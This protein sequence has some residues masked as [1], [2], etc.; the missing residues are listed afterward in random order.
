MKY[1]AELN[2]G[3][4]KYDPEDE[5]VSG[6]MDKLDVVNAAAERS[7]GFV[8]RL[9]DTDEGG[10]TISAYDDPRFLINLSVWENAESFEKFVWQTVHKRVYNQKGDWFEH[11]TEPNLVM[12]WIDPDHRPSLE[13]ALER[14]EYLR[15][16][17]PS[18]YAFGWSE[19]ESAELYKSKQCA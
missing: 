18:D 4:L 16:H 3:K 1:L 13:E 6:F 12:W 9:K 5:R 7:E 11:S 10:D 14:L 2:V 15:K 19:L 8:W 17:G